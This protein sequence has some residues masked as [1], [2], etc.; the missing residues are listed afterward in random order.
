MEFNITVNFICYSHT[1]YISWVSHRLKVTY[2]SSRI[3]IFQIFEIEHDPTKNIT[4]SEIIYI[5]V[6]VGMCYSLKKVNIPFE[7]V[8]DF[9]GALLGYVFSFFIPILIHL[10]CLHFDHSSGYIKGDH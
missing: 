6:I 7:L 4:I 1:N 3:R 10:K 9:T 8:L 2:F 5:V